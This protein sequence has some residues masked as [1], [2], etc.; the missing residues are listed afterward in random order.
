MFFLETNGLENS[1]LFLGLWQL[2]S[3]RNVK[4]Q[5]QAPPL[6]PW[7]FRNHHGGSFCCCVRVGD[8]PKGTWELDSWMT[9][10]LQ[11]DLARVGQTW[12]TL[13]CPLTFSY[14]NYRLLFLVLRDLSDFSASTSFLFSSVSWLLRHD[15]IVRPIQCHYI[16]Q[17]VT[18][19]LIL[20]RWRTSPGLQMTVLTKYFILA[21]ILFIKVILFHKKSYSLFPIC[22]G[23]V[24]S[25]IAS[26]IFQMILII[27]AFCLFSIW[28]GVAWWNYG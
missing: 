24:S 11:R 12:A 25:V 15:R 14:L 7:W 4:Q 19:G 22:I 9:W 16:Y 8:Q 5:A 13:E 20:N 6:K 10:G 1:L 3:P 26:K 17:P 27:V 23:A 21:I 2:P 18:S 28:S